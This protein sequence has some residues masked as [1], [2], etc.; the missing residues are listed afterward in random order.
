M[1][2][3]DV[4]QNVKTIAAVPNRL[5]GGGWPDVLEVRG[6]VFL[7]LT[8][9]EELNQRLTE[10]GKPPFANPRNSAAGSLRQKDPRITASRALNMIVHG[11]GR[12]EGLAD[13]PQAQSGWYERLRAVGTAGQRP[14]PGRARH[15]RRTEVHH[16]LRGAPA[17]PAVRDRRRRRQDR[18]AGRAAPAGRDQPCPAVGDRLQVPA[19]GGQYPAA[20]HPGECRPDRAGDAVRGDGAG[21]GQRVHGRERDACTTPTRSRARACS[22]ATWWSCARPATSSRRWSGP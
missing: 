16:S 18:H 11:I 15:R 8:A 12:V 14:V 1:T 7:P 10:A 22:S 20:R 17:R 4:T 13:P 5:A 6:E 21:Q 2:G 3:E 19:G 9:F